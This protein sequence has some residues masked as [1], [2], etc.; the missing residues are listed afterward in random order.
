MIMACNPI[1]EAFGGAGVCKI[2]PLVLTPAGEVQGE[3][4]ASSGYQLPSAAA[5]VLVV[6]V[7]LATQSVA[8]GLLLLREFP[9]PL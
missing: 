3:L 1:L 2:E 4:L 5:A 9:Q 7:L 6:T 8:P